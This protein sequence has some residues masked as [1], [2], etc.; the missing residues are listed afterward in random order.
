MKKLI[1][2]LLT[3]A[4]SCGSMLAVTAAFCAF[5]PK[6]FSTTKADVISEKKLQYFKLEKPIDVFREEQTVYIAQKDL[7]VIYY[8][9]TYR[10]LKPSTAYYEAYGKRCEFNISSMSKCGNA[11]LFLS[12][13]KLYAVELS[14]FSISKTPLLNGVSAFS[15][16]G[17]R[18]IASVSSETDKQIKFYEYNSSSGEL[19]SEFIPYYAQTTINGKGAPSS[20]ALVEADDVNKKAAY[21]F[22]SEELYVSQ[23]KDILHVSDQTPTA[24]EYADGKLYVRAK[25][26][27]SDIVYLLESDN[28]LTP[29]LSLNENGLNGANGFFV[30][31]EKILVCDTERDRVVEFDV[32][33]KTFTDFEISFTKIDLPNDFA[34]TQTETPMSVSVSPEDALYNVNLSASANNGYFVFSGSYK[35]NGKTTSSEYLVAATVGS[36][37]YL[38]LG[39]CMALVLKDDYEP[40]PIATH[41][42]NSKKL[43]FTNDCAVYNLP[44]KTADKTLDLGH[45]SENDAAF[46]KAFAAKRGTEATVISTL[47]LRG[48]EFTYLS[49]EQGK[50]YIPSACL[51]EKTEEA[52]ARSNFKTATTARK[53]TYV[54]SDS[55]LSTVAAELPSYSDVLVYSTDNGVCYVSYGNGEYGYIEQ[56]ALEK[57]GDFAK[58]MVAVCILLAL[59]VC[60]TAVYFENKYLYSKKK[61]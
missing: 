55:N 29:I 39:D 38:I 22:G 50:G 43:V 61:D 42:G 31:D 41:Y 27:A 11:L 36:D 17:N 34:I 52:P 9:D 13:E 24:L 35:P 8:D 57:R 4:L 32:A 49:C 5:K 51:T 18:F 21:Y 12:N 14:S 1:A 23:N 16:N 25:A 58:R 2:A 28:S 44:Y 33:T 47:T 10:T 7:I 53:T 56:G 19:F 46:F 54:Y 37:Y 40:T 59:S 15:V 60:L 48:I 30:L 20:L 6:N 26:A 45:N 3:L